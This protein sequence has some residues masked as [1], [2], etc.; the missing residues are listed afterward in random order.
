MKR[1]LSVIISIVMILALS[2]NAMAVDTA[3]TIT[4]DTTTRDYKAFM[5]LEASVSGTNF[6]YKV[7]EKYMDI[8]VDEL[9]LDA[10]TATS[11]KIVDA[12]SRLTAADDMR[13]FADDVY[14]QI[15][16]KG[17][18]DDAS[19]TG[20][21]ATLPQ[22]YW[23]IADVTDLSTQNKSNSLVM[24]DTLGDTSVSI[25]AKP[26]EITTDK[27]VDDENDSLVNPADKNLEATPHSEDETQL[28]DTAD[29]DIGD[30]VPYRITIDMPNNAAAYKYYSFIISDNV[31]EGLTYDPSTFKISMPNTGIEPVLAEKNS[32]EAATADFIY[33]IETDTDAEGNQTA[34]RL[35]VY[36]AKGYTTNEGKY[37]DPSKTV[38]GDYLSIFA[39]GT[40]HNVINQ[41]TVVFDYKCL[42]NEN[43]VIGVEGN[44]NDYQLKYSNNP[45][46]DT[47]GQTPEDTVI[48]FTYKVT[49][50]KVDSNKN[51]LEGADF[52]LYKF[53]ASYVVDEVTPEKEAELT[54]Q[55]YEKN[56][57]A[58][59]WGKYIPVAIKKTNADTTSGNPTTFSFE[60]LD[61]GYYKLEETV[62]P[63]GYNSIEPVVFKVTANHVKM[64]DGST[65]L[66][67]LEAKSTVG[68]A[69]S[70]ASTDTNGAV[71]GELTSDVENRSG[72]EL[73][74]TGGIGR[75]IFYVTGSV[76]F[77]GA[78]I[79]L[80]T[81]KRMKEEIA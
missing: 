62:T 39:D 57:T 53:V 36:P 31:E 46:G 6:A 61:D 1:F 77:I 9:G 10:A 22:G 75:T 17:I 78:V 66:S 70:F 68:G 54:A 63:V 80:I 35:Y 60:G 64:I 67:G 14:R 28:Q 25:N 32:P 24:V 49:F 11:E 72:S 56:A 74:S 21:S 73:P 4:G 55:G 3:I 51:P 38:G 58:G 34:Q 52:T 79:F 23:L 19:W 40:L 37:N 18:A 76:V 81:K 50:N 42:L 30:L 59:A 43:A 47:F 33:E 69:I 12:I 13:H 45:F 2:V 8:L 29:Y 5:L 65:M 16:E 15:I 48:V 20:E 27:K 41:S 71:T 26:D 44:P 7:N